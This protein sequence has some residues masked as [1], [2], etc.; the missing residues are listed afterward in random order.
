MKHSINDLLVDC[1][2]ITLWTPTDLLINGKKIPINSDNWNSYDLWKTIK[3]TVA[4]LPITTQFE[5]K[6]LF[7]DGYGF[8]IRYG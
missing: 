1:P 7:T 6:G 2:W 8:T 3:D 5:I 4:K